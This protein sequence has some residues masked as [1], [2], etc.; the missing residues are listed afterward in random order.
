MKQCITFLAVMLWLMS[1]AHAW[2][3]ELNAPLKEGKKVRLEREHLLFEKQEAPPAIQEF[4]EE[5]GWRSGR[6][7][8][9]DDAD[10]EDYPWQ[11]ALMQGT[12]QFCGGSVIGEE[13]IL[14]AAHCVVGPWT[15]E[16]IRAGVTNITDSNQDI[17]VA[18]IIVHPD[19]VSATAGYDIALIKVAEPFDLTDPAVGSIHIVTQADADDGLT[20][21]DVASAVSGWGSL[22]SGG[23]SPDI[24]QVVYVPIVSNEDA[25][26]P[27]LYAPGSITDDMLCAGDLEDGGIDACQGDSGGPL[28]VPDGSGGY[29]VAGITSWGQGCAEPGYPG[30]YARVS[31]FEDW[32]DGIVN[33]PEPDGSVTATYNAGNIPTD[34]DFQS[35]PGSSSCPGSLTVTIPAGAEILSVDVEY[36]MTAQNMA[37]MSEQRSQLR[38]VSPGGADEGSLF[39]GPSANEGTHSYSRSRLAIANDVAGGG[40][41]EFELHAGRTWG[42]SGCNT[43]YNY[44]ANN[45]WSV[46]VHYKLTGPEYTVTFNVQG[47]DNDPIAGAT[48]NIEGQQLTTGANGQASTQLTDGSYT[49]NTTATDY[50]AETTPFAVD[51]D[52][53]TVTIQL[54]DLI[55]EPVNLAIDTKGV[56]PGE[57]LFSWEMPAPPPAMTFTE[58][59]DGYDDWT[60]NLSPWTTIDAH[61]GITYG[62]NAFDFPPLESSEFAWGIMNPAQTSPSIEETHPAYSGSKYVISV[63]QVDTPAT[64]E[65][66]KWLISPQMEV[67]EGSVLSFAAKSITDQYGL[68]RLK[69]YVSTTGTNPGDFTMIS[70]GD[71][72]EVPTS[73]TEYSY[74]LDAYAGQAIYLAVENV[75]YDS[76]MLFLDAFEVTEVVNDRGALYTDKAF[77]GFNVYL[78]DMETP[79]ANEI[80]ETE[81]LYAG[82]AE[83][84]HTAGVQAVYSSGTSD[85]KTISFE[86][87][88]HETEWIGLDEDW[89]DTDNWTDGVPTAHSDAAIPASLAYYPTI[90]EPA[91]VGVLTLENGATLLDNDN[92]TIHGDFIMER[93]I[94]HGGW[95]MISAPVSDMTIAGSDFV[96][97][98]T[99]FDFY[100]FDESADNN[101]PWVNFRGDNFSDSHFVP[102]KGYLVAYDAFKEDPLPFAF[103]GTM[104]TGDVSI[105]LSYAN[106]WSWGGWNL[107]GNPY[108]SAIDWHDALH[109]LMEDNYAYVYDRESTHEGF[110]EG[111]QPVDGG[112]PGAIIAAN[113]GFFVKMEDLGSDNFTFSNTMRVH[114]GEFA[115]EEA[116][117]GDRLV[118]NLSGDGYFDRTTLRVR[119]NA[120]FG[121]DRSDALKLF[122]YNDAMPQLYSYTADGVKAAINTMPFVDEEEPVMLGMH[123]PSSGGY[124]ISVEEISG[125]YSTQH[126][127]LEDMQTGSAHDLQSNP[128]YAFTTDEGDISG[129][130]NLHFDKQDDDATGMDCTESPVAIIWHHSNT[131]YVKSRD[132]N[133]EVR[134]YDIN[135]RQLQHY[136]PGVG[137]HSY[138][139]ILPAGVYIIHM[140]TSTTQESLRI[141]VE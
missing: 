100:Y 108:P 56:D 138:Q 113:Q 89:F 114:G 68:E 58:N 69:V 127:M 99:T 104:N 40:D 90:D 84:T 71:F 28:A 105:S 32:I 109:T 26:D 30:V 86:V 61:G 60:T 34:F 64:N 66:N 27:G 33:A 134:L 5:H 76:F 77:K 16:Y 87:E 91:E 31:Y 13:W 139:I 42:G 4:V 70:T 57:A 19:Y 74:P 135:R 111:Y 141:V 123:I 59:W 2:E 3:S 118:L 126:I 36:N 94:P 103:E 137:E 78:N 24:L 35:L 117:A 128:E 140:H 93:D 73:W 132:N 11:V 55:E 95:R 29:K 23:P 98:D 14:T 101:L 129:R 15:A 80:A 112:S 125:I 122:S 83:G 20:D 63:A 43:T 39:S 82:L 107:I 44:V 136:Q 96:P 120:S 62:A 88:Q 121:R 7:V 48:V 50:V 6:I 1:L 38:C 67:T 72:E 124:V 75:S 9:G 102:G 79:V 22:S 131:I 47:H 8:G 46:T 130:F 116:P 37:W 25:M 49:A 12:T 21:P 115:K 18:E 10:I 53:K 54:E 85:I 119:E 65:E 52:D 45:T 97:D 81:H 92:L 133:T 17:A 41:I 110:T 106:S 51:G